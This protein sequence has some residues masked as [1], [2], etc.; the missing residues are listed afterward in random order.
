MKYK[1]AI[2]QFAKWKTLQ[3]KQGTIYGYYWQLVNFGIFVKNKDIDKITEKDITD[4][5][6]WSD[7]FGHRGSTKEK[8]AIAIKKLLEYCQLKGIDCEQ[9]QLV[10]IIKKDRTFPRVANESDYYKL[11]NIIPVSGYNHIRNRAIIALLYDSGA[12][13]GEIISLNI[14]D[15]DIEN[16]QCIIKTE[17]NNSFR[18]IFF[19]EATIVYLNTWI[20]K[21][22]QILEHLTIEDKNALFVSV[23][24]GACGEG[25][26]ARRCDIA[27]AGE[28]L[29]KYSKMA[30]LKSTFNAHSLR[31]RYGRVLAEKGANNSVISQLMGHNNIDSSKVYTDLFSGTLKK[32][33]H[34]VFG[35]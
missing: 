9:P 30:G 3:V 22:E 12:R 14:S 13:L 10:P 1:D 20:K 28:M 32:I 16:K 35:E 26:N 33:Y 11:L 34:G 25:T 24:G 18:N 5:L 29:R 7:F 19:R 27:A 4:Y 21:R 8:Q 15:I 17:K 2:N 6:Y 23:V 31:H